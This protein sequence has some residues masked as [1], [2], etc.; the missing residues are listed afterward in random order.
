MRRGASAL[1]SPFNEGPGSMSFRPKR[2]D[3]GHLLRFWSLAGFFFVGCDA[4]QDR[5]YPVAENDRSASIPNL[6]ATT[7]L[8]IG[9]IS[10][11]G[12]GVF[13]DIGAFAVSK[14]GKIFI[15]D[16]QSQEIRVFGSD[17]EPLFAFGRKG[18][19]PGEMLG[20]AGLDFGPHGLLWVWDF[21]NHRFSGFDETGSFVESF[22]REATGV[23][24]GWRG[25]F[26]GGK[27]Y[28]FGVEFIQAGDALP[29]GRGTRVLPYRTDPSGAKWEQL[30]VLE[31]EYD[32]NEEGIPRPLAGQLTFHVSPDGDLVAGHQARY[33][34]WKIAPS[35]DTLREIRVSHRKM[36]QT[37]A[38]LDSVAGQPWGPSRKRI[39]PGD[40]PA[41]RL[42]FRRMFFATDGRMFVAAT[43]GDQDGLKNRL[44]DVF[45][46]GGNLIARLVT[47][48]PLG[49]SPLP[50]VLGDTIHAVTK[51]HNDVE[52]FVRLVISAEN[53]RKEES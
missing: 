32:L 1:Q 16:Y 47:D 37:K 26:A 48:V 31:G 35:G 22:K 43:D 7:D 34:I 21:R 8:R 15:L 45:S 9:E 28:D 20:A 41:N 29:F 39:R 53:Q 24:F 27:L 18:E 12:L 46:P 50:R 33:V 10:G 30:P 51:D 4:P 42:G 6:Q 11:P 19:G 25:G 5:D 38:D 2:T 40:V 17:G 52:Y 44:Y 3:L 36:G 13:G 14:A 23:V 49:N